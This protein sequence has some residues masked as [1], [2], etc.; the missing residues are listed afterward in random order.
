MPEKD[1]Y[2]RFEIHSKPL[3]CVQNN[4]V[5]VSAESVFLLCPSHDDCDGHNSFVINIFRVKQ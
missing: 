4:L 5:V 3:T 2:R 1:T